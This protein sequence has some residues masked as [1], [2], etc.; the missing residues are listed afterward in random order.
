MAKIKKSVSNFL[1]EIQNGIFDNNLIP[2]N[3]ILMI[4]KMR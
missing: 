2:A 4:M 3:E 1:W